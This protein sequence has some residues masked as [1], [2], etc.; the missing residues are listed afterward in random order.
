MNLDAKLTEL[1]AE[2]AQPGWD[3]YSAQPVT[4]AVIDAAR[5]FLALLPEDVPQPEIFPS[6]DG[7]VEVGWENGD[8]WL[9]V[10]IQPDGTLACAV[11]VAGQGHTGRVVPCEVVP[12]V[13]LKLIREVWAS[14]RP[15]SMTPE[16][17][18]GRTAAWCG[19]TVRTRL[20]YNR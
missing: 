1:A 18:G 19:L 9:Y 13:I 15:P 5:R 8:N 17:S 3:S 6:P 20:R 14:P 10:S 12:P 4:A 16:P 2:C 11:M 7:C